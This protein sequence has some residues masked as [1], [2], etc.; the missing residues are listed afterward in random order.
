MAET[1]E[2]RGGEARVLAQLAIEGSGEPSAYEPSLDWG[3]PP[4]RFCVPV[5]VGPDEKA[6]CPIWT[7]VL[8]GVA[9]QG[10]NEREA[11]ENIKEAL[12][13]AIEEYRASGQEIPWQPEEEPSRGDE[14]LR[15]VWIDVP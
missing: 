14:R 7:P 5:L 8:P 6:G 4:A 13:G 9:S 10:R 2:L 11:L 12:A 15:W 3:T 1:L